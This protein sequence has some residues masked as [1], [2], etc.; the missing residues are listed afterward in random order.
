NV[1]IGV[2]KVIKILDHLQCGGAIMYSEDQGTASKRRT[3]GLGGAILPADV[4]AASDISHQLRHVGNEVSIILCAFILDRPL[5]RD[6]RVQPADRQAVSSDVKRRA[7]ASA[8]ALRVALTNVVHGDNDRI[9]FDLFKLRCS[10]LRKD[11]RSRTKKD[12]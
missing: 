8:E 12:R 10:G 6:V 1:I 2:S 4:D 3:H 11:S 9:C 5:E 7:S